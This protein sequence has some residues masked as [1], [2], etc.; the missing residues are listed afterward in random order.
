MT[1]ASLSDYTA[2]APIGSPCNVFGNEPAASAESTKTTTSNAGPT[3]SVLPPNT[4][5]TLAQCSSTPAFWAGIEGP[6]TDKIQGDRS[7]TTT[8]QTNNPVIFGCASNAANAANAEYDELGHF[9]TIHVEPQ[10]VNQAINLQLYDPAWVHTGSTCNYLT[11]ATRNTPPLDFTATN[12]M[13]PYAPDAAV[14]TR[15]RP[16]RASAPATRSSPP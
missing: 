14:A 4:D 16:R 2:P 1:R 15:P 10:A 5:A 13:N 12:G 3:G 7:M 11:K 6:R 8:C 9:L